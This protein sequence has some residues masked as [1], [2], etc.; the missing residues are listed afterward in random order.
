MPFFSHNGAELYYELHGSGPA[1]LMLAGLASDCQSWLPVLA[2]LEQQFSLILMDNRGVGRSSQGCE[3]SIELMADDAMALLTRL[4]L[5]KVNLLG[6][7]M[8]GM[9]A[10]QCAVR[11]PQ[12]VEKL[13]LVATASHNSARNNR[14]FADWASAREGDADQAAWFRAIFAW[15]FRDVFFEDSQCVDDVVKSLLCYAWPQTAQ[16]FRK[17]VQAIAAFDGTCLLPLVALP[18]LVVAGEQDILMP[19]KASGALV[20][21]IRGAQLSVIEQSAHSLCMEQPDQFVRVVASFFKNY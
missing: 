17:Q 1:L 11:Y 12:L 7:S 21:G 15:I 2:D 13:A 8:G 3:I 5:E 14:L 19:L 4:G 18:T 10:L 6:H 20:E 9:V 16:G